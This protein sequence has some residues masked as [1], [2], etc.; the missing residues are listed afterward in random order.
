MLQEVGQAEAGFEASARVVQMMQEQGWEDDVI[1]ALAMIAKHYE[2][3]DDPQIM[4]QV[5][6]MQVNSLLIQ[7]QKAEDAQK[8]Q[9]HTQILKKLEE[10]VAASKQSPQILNL[11]LQVSS[12]FESSGKMENSLAYLTMA[13]TAFATSSNPKIPEL[14]DQQL[15][16]AQKRTGLVGQEFVVEGLLI[17]G[18]KFD[19]SKYKGKVV[20]IDFWATWCAPC[21]EEIPNIEANYET[22]REQGF[23]VVGISM[24]DTTAEVKEFLDKQPLPWPTVF[25]SDPAKVG[26]DCP[27]AERCGVNAIPFVVLVGKD[28]KVD[29][30]HMR[31]K[32]LGERLE[33][34]FGVAAPNPSSDASKVSPAAEKA[35]AADDSA[36]TELAK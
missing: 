26:Y 20:L 36:K 14:I 8:S 15:A 5:M 2:K 28:G 12:L 18:E 30:I 9:F 31:G 29:G 24:D 4:L 7:Y 11:I 32:R 35:T 6:S 19:W 25:S 3:S 23:E 34:L 13:K 16:S 27:M 33:K 17:N 22:Y 21:L 1:A 10:M